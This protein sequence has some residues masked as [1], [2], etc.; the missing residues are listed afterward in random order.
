MTADDLTIDRVTTAL[1]L[2]DLQNFNRG[3]PTQPLSGR[4]VLAN[5]VRLAESCANGKYWWC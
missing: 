1:I 5:A 2:V 4:A 3:L